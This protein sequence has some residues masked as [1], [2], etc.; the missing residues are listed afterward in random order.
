MQ[1]IVE[2]EKTVEEAQKDLEQAVADNQ[3]G[4]LHVHDLKATLNKKG[5]D[6]V[7]D[8]RIYEICNPQ[9]ASAVLTEDMSL[10]MALPCRISI[11]QEKGRVKIGTLQ[12][13]AILASLSDSAELMT[14]AKEVES[15]INTI[16]DQ[17]K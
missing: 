16:I 3:F 13:T 4:I 14:V 6:F 5:I 15:V 9:Q 7:N 10:N 11:W 2:T 8:C 12:P 17:A 1:Y